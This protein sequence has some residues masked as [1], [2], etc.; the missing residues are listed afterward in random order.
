MGRY[1]ATQ[2]EAILR[3]IKL[4][5][6]PHPLVFDYGTE[7]LARPGESAGS[8]V[9]LVRL[10]VPA[11][12]VALLIAATLYGLA[13]NRLC[14]LLGFVFFAILAPNSL[15]PGNHQTAAEHRMYLALIPVVLLG[16]LGIFQWL[17]R[18]AFPACLLLAAGM[19]LVS[20][21]RNQDFS[22]ELAIWN[23]TVAKKP[24]N[25]LA[26]LNLGN[27][28][29]S[30]PGRTESAIAE[31]EETL[32][33][34]PDYVQAHNNLGVL[35][36]AT[37]GRMQD[38]IGHYEEALRLAPGYAEAHY[39]LGNA[40]DALG[41]TPDAIAQFQEA[42]RLKPDLVAARCNL[43]I[44]LDTLGQTPAA[45]A[46]YEEALRLR[47]DDPVIL[48]DLALELLKSPGHADEAA[49]RIRE[50]IRLQPG[51]TAALQTLRRISP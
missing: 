47:P 14:G 21:K 1:W 43:G 24:E 23:D 29:S 39:N 12:I 17:G 41:R 26:H 51:N 28:W 15:I 33:L 30:I 11:A 7:W 37:P 32:R 48:Y 45:I 4:A 6:W 5:V 42:V 20:A 46:Q 19:G 13:R 10:V 9:I 40:L 25:P 44:D 2:P 3:Y 8:W 22:S 36:A 18:A 35:L 38:A 49:T 27:A 34:K 50:V 16:V 31:Y